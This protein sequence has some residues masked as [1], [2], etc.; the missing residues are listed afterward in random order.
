MSTAAE[1]RLESSQERLTQVLHWLEEGQLDELDR[2]LSELHPAEIA[3]LLESLPHDQREAVWERVPAEQE[4]E[5]LLYVNDEVRSG[6]IREMDRDELVAATEGMDTDDLADILP[7]LPEPVISELL[8]SMSEQDRQRLETVLVYPDDTAGGLMNLDTVTI[9]P[10]VSL[11]VVLRYLRF[12]GELPEPTDSLFVV[13]RE[14]K[15]LGRVRLIELVTSDPS[16][17]VAEILDRELDPIPADTPA[18]EVARLFEDRDLISAPVVDENGKLIGRITIDDVVDLIREQADHDI[19]ARSGLDE[20]DDMFAPV[21]R[22]SR[23]RAVW[24]G[25]NLVTAFLAA[26]VIGLFDETIEKV[27]A[28]A[29]LMPIVASMGGIAG[30]QTLTLVIRGLALGQISASNAW[31]LMRKEVLVALVNGLLWAVVVAIVAI[32]WFHDL[33]LGMVIGVAIVINLLV[34][35]VA[36]AVI[37]LVLQRLGAD[38]ALAGGVVLTT[39]TDVVGFLAFLGLATLVLL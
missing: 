31:G 33:T 4:G 10:H 28:L 11:E 34:A 15:Y 18:N 9:R 20:E 3:N 1:N 6:L 35:A 7:D 26:W 25:V 27:V 39:V 2:L 23:R 21:L 36:G 16:L 24:L 22:S 8:Q 13:N 30:T 5:I 29:V 14:D 19:M 17:T 37:P 32:A 38:P 12:R